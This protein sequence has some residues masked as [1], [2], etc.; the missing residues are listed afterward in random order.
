[1]F[2]NNLNICIEVLS[3]FFAT[4]YIVFISPSILQPI[5]TVINI[6]VIVIFLI[7]IIFYF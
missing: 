7:F 2:H 3:F 4:L 5:I 1:M 6:I